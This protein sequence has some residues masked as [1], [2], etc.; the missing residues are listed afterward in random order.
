MIH[1]T[2]QI[3]PDA[4]I[5]KNV[6]IGAYCKIDYHVVLADN[7]ILEPHVTIASQSQIGES[8]H[9]YPFVHIGNG[10]TNIVIK[11]NCHIREFTRIATEEK[12][13]KPVS[14]QKHCYIMAYTDIKEHVTLEEY[15]TITNHVILNSGVI[16]E[17]RVIIGA[18]AAIASDCTIGTGCMIGGVSKVTHDIPPFCLVEG[19]PI[20]K[21]RGL[22]LI[23]MRRSFD[24]RDSINHV[25]KCFLALKKTSFDSSYAQMFLETIDDPHAKHL[26]RF[27][28]NHTIGQ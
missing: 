2:A 7:V 4:I 21:I 11:E 6:S 13:S 27:V 8:S 22:N 5:G 12:A 9:L 25:K 28:A 14:I 15:C 10:K 17:K 23:G 18:K 16:C 20:A 1:P 3:A 24:D 26:A 19:S